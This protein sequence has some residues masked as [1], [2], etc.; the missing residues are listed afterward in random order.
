MT[1]EKY[2]WVTPNI[3]DTANWKKSIDIQILLHFLLSFFNDKDSF[4]R[5]CSGRSAS[6]KKGMQLFG[7]LCDTIPPGK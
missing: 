7:L 3:E 5:I 1:S 6:T 4:F 2:I